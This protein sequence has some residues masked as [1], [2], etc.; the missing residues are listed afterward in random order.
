M[1]KPRAMRHSPPV[2]AV[3]EQARKRP[4][5]PLLRFLGA[6]QTVTGSRF[7]IDTPAAR[8]LVDC[9]L[10]QGLKALRERN[11][12]TF[13][14]DPASIDAVVL[15]HAHLDHTGYV[16][17]LA[18]NGFSGRLF[19]TEGT[20]ALSRIV[21]PD[22]GHIQEEDAAYANRKGF[23]KHLPALPLYTEEDA[24]RAVQRF[25]AVPY[26]TAH[27]VATGVRVTFRPAG[28][29][30]GSASVAIDLA[31]GTQRSLVFSGDLGRPHH[32]ILRPPAPL[33]AADVVL[34][35]STYG[36]RQHEDVE[37][38]RRFEEA[39]VRT[40]ERR[41][42]VLIPSFAVDRTEVILFHLR[43]LAHAGRIPALPVYV[44]SPMAL[45]TLEIYRRALAE[46]SPEVRH[47]LQE[48]G[49]PFDPGQLIEARR[50]EESIAINEQPG[51]AIIISASGMA[52]GG[53]V[54]HH[55]MHRLPEPRNT[56]LLV[57]FQAEG[58]RGRSLLEG[59]RAVKMLG[60]YIAV[61]AEVVDVPAFSVHADQRELISW[62]KTAR[63]PPEMTFIV[64]GEKVASESLHGA[65][66]RQLGW[67]AAVPNYMEQ[68]RLD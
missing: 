66:E 23:S 12:A 43:N 60:R 68:V 41:G 47:E 51:P 45:A 14:V 24:L 40:A 64:H 54:L 49:D 5:V 20:V 2:A 61:R 35:E 31:A 11:W 32:P 56:V 26:D 21:L 29:I 39:I 59:A 28:H 57:G 10:F 65:I 42:V 4:S 15:T 13:P 55:L 27:E 58:T 17:A 7:L 62:L 52:T 46:G 34:V 1:P 9:G 22:S 50:V 67:T 30:L 63:H 36:D 18:R 38:L 25:T 3:P 37:S 8:V 33:P 19:A 53:R 44:D 6:T 16:P 48:A